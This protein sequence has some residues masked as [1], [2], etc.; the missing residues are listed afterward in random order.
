MEEIERALIVKTL[1]RHGH[2][3]CKAAAALGMTRQALYRR[4]EKYG[5]QS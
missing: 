3:I 1:E 5:I 2:N 4:L